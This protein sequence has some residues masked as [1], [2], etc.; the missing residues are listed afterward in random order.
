M[1]LDGVSIVPTLLGEG[2]QVDRSHL[3]WEYHSS[4]GIQAVRMGDWKGVRRSA[5]SNPDGVIELY[6]LENDPFETED[7]VFQYPGIARQICEI[8]ANDRSPSIYSNWNFC[9]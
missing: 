9:Q 3:Y 4:G 8:M 5:Y 1:E 2:T 7:L 6:D